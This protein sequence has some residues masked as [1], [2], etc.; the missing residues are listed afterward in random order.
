VLLSTVTQELVRDTLPSD[1]QLLDMGEHRLKDL[2]RPEHIFQLIVIGLPSEFPPLN[3]LDVRPNNLPLQPTP[4]VGREKELAQVQKLLGREHRE[5]RLVTLTGPGGTGKTRL[6][7]QVAS[8]ALDDYPEGV[9]FVDLSSLKDGGLVLPT[10]ADALSVRE[11]AGQPL[12]DTLKAYLK[13]KALL[14]VLDNFEQVA[15][16]APQVSQL[17]ASCPQL[18]VLVTSRVPLSIRGEHEYAVPPLQLPN[19]QDLPPLELLTQYEA[20][21][22]FIE[23]ATEV[24]ADFQVTNDNAPAVAAI[25]VRLDGLPLAI[26]LAAARVRMLSPDALLSRL[27]QRLRVLTG[28]AKDLPARQ[29]TLR[30]T[31]EWSYDLLDED[32]KQLFW[33]MAPFSGGSSLEA[34]EAVCNA[35]ALQI[36]GQLGKPAIDVFE[37]ASSL[38][39]KNLLREV[40]EEGSGRSGRGSRK[41]GEPRFRLLETIHEYARE[42]LEESGEE[43]ALLREHALYFMKLAEEAEAHLTGARQQEWLDRLED[44]HDNLRAALGWSRDAQEAR[45]AREADKETELGEGEEE[46]AIEAKEVGLRIAGAIWRFWLVRGHHSEGREQLLALFGGHEAE[47]GAARAKALHGAG[48]LAW[49]QGEY[50]GA[51]RLLEE[52]LAIRRKLSDNWGIAATLNNLGLV[53]RSQGDYASA[54]SLYEEGLTLFRELDDKWSIAAALNNLGNVAYVQGDYASARS[55]SEESLATC[56]ELGDK[57]GIAS[58]LANLGNVA[59]V[60]GE[61]ASARSLYEESLAIR[62]EL[63]DSWTIAHSL[64]NLGNVAYVQGEYAAAHSLYKESLAIKREMGDMGDKW[65]I[66]AS[67]AGLGS[68]AA[69]MGT[70]I[71]TGMGLAQAQ[72]GAKL[73]GAAEALLEAISAVL[74]PEERMVYEQGEASAR[75]QLSEEEFEKAWQEGRAMSTEQAVEYALQGTEDE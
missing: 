9:W 61:Y 30:N 36:E 20:V 40:E 35:E 74:E 49:A 64:N 11:A 31:I 43:E 73:L 62:R 46:G 12:I 50:P 34:L 15:E 67:L 51:R 54:R 13:D 23:R 58:S 22:L 14:L 5:V 52:S 60:Q 39:S 27:S 66:A 17:L 32:E 8:E 56:R 41:G 4:L 25:C 65:D 16:T 71:G 72:R 53:A 75:S 69:G 42:K 37:G 21:R 24:K 1:V 6:G 18:K 55:L 3:T 2:T 59:Y 45:E 26:E 68:V 7:L 29:Q 10:I 48:T 38:L 47:W 19:A 63:E 57:W 44:E 70:G 33:R 28:G